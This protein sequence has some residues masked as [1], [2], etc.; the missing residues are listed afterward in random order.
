MLLI[1][2]PSFVQV[3]EA[4]VINK[5]KRIVTEANLSTSQAVREQH[6]R[7]ESYHTYVYISGSCRKL[8]NNHLDFV[9]DN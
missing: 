8:Q 5:L 7:D 2:H 3:V 4:Q 1:K 9:I 6:G